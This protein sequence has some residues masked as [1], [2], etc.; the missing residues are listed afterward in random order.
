MLALNFKTLPNMSV[1]GSDHHFQE[2]WLG[3]GDV[4]SFLCILKSVSANQSGGSVWK[5]VSCICTCYAGPS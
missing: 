1:Y 2:Q 5:L 3:A 4:I